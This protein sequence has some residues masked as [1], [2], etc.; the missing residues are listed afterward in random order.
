MRIHRVRENESVYDI[1]REY[2][3]SPLKII[4]NNE[5]ENGRRLSVGHELLILIPTRTYNVKKGDSLDSIA[6]RFGTKSE[7]IKSFNP[8]LYN[9]DAL[10]S[11][12]LLAIKYD[13]PA[14]GMG[15]ANGYYYAGC[16]RENVMR[17]L[18]YMSYMTVCSAKALENGEI[19]VLFD[20]VEL[21]NLAKKNGIIPLMRIYMPDSQMLGDEFVGSAAILAKS[22]G[23]LGITL[24]SPVCGNKGC[25]ELDGMLLNMRKRLMELDL[26]LFIEADI[27]GGCGCSEYADGCV[28]T[29]DKI[30]L[31]EIPSFEDG[32][33]R[34]MISFAERCDSSRAFIDISPFA[35]CGDK[36]IDK[37]AA[38]SVCDRQ[39]GVLGY[40][41]ERM[42]LTGE[43]G[44]GRRAKTL[45]SESLENTK[46]KLRLISELGYMG[47]SFDI[48]RTP[49]SEL[50]LF[51]VMFSMPP[52]SVRAPKCNP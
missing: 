39:R 6:R 50:L 4:E 5:L 46:A 37:R 9:E 14:Y 15:A 8:E 7:T 42:I 2:G 38:Y 32:E 22:R 35:Y 24:S 26:Y 21:I 11:G 31:S 52:T 19:S 34:A 28:L 10:Y 27:N 48:M 17:A 44:R 47:I 43:L 3:V 45:V 29:Y 18:P 40:D 30:H 16:P 49:L 51:S 36:Y 20:D 1:G 41:E 13:A 33:M 23:Y 12:Q 25:D